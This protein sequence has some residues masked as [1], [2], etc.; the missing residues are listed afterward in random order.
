MEEVS[1]YSN[2]FRWFSHISHFIAGNDANGSRILAEYRAAKELEEDDLSDDEALPPV[3]SP[4]RIQRTITPHKFITFV[5]SPAGPCDFKEL[6]E[7]IRSISPSGLAWMKAR[8]VGSTLEIEADLSSTLFSASDIKD[9][10]SCLD[11]IS[12]VK[13]K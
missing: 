1:K 10:L 2:V 13:V 5:V 11:N 4:T 3:F 9:E 12:S 6:E 8:V 7:D